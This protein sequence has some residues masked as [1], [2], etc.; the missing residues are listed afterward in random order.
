[1]KSYIHLFLKCI[2]QQEKV[3]NTRI[4]NKHFDRHKIN[5]DLVLYTEGMCQPIPDMKTII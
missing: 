3:Q 1:M 2:K 4:L 5:K